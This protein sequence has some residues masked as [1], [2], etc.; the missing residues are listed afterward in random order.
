[1]SADLSGL[2]PMR[3]K[4]VVLAHS[5][6]AARDAS[7]DDDNAD[8]DDDDDDGDDGD[9]DLGHDAGSSEALAAAGA[10]AWKRAAATLGD[11]TLPCDSFQTS[12]SSCYSNLIWSPK[13]SKTI[14]KKTLREDQMINACVGLFPSRLPLPHVVCC[15]S[16]LAS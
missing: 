4:G 12:V 15:V 14:A 5:S 13:H 16:I 10:L 3:P 11:G 8:D 7:D 9:D 1:M 6:T 2:K